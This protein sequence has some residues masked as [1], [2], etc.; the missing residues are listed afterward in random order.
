MGSLP[1][2]VVLCTPALSS[3]ATRAA[4]AF[5]LKP[6]CAARTSFPAS[7][8]LCLLCVPHKRGFPG[9]GC[10]MCTPSPRTEQAVKAAVIKGLTCCCFCSLLFCGTHAENAAE[11]LSP[12]ISKFLL[13][14]SSLAS[15]PLQKRMLGIPHAHPIFL[16]SFPSQQS[17]R[18][19]FSGG[20]GGDAIA[21]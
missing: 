14:P 1:P 19:L 20:R 13:A 16:S 2:S 21:N 12:Q 9:S 17:T 8:T 15:V 4:V 7:R 10:Q 3:T 11:S 6:R 18:D 5:G